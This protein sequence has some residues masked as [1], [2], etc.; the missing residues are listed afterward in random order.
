MPN[1]NK[2]YVLNGFFWGGGGYFWGGYFNFFIHFSL[3]SPSLPAPSPAVSWPFGPS[4]WWVWGK[5]KKRKEKKE[6]RTNPRQPFAPGPAFQLSAPGS[7]KSDLVALLGAISLRKNQHAHPSADDCERL[8]LHRCHV[9]FILP[10]EV[11]KVAVA[12]QAGSQGETSTAVSEESVQ[13]RL[14]FIH[15]PVLPH[16]KVLISGML[17]KRVQPPSR[18]SFYPACCS[19]F[20][21]PVTNS[22][23]LFYILFPFPLPS[24]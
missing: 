16:E 11:G 5:E 24:F 18:P 4:K 3:Q 13:V 15:T 20:P 22:F 9:P 7:T 19:S 1:N 17:I 14:D 2:N 10:G 12:L 6:K 21:C 8:L 23:F